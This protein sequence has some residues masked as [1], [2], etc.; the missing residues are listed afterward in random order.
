M[1]NLEP[2]KSAMSFLAVD[3]T[4]LALPSADRC[5]S[6]QQRVLEQVQTMRMHRSR[7]PSN[8]SGSPASKKRTGI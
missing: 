3:D 6:G 4:S 7:H 1:T 8:T 2:L 5:R